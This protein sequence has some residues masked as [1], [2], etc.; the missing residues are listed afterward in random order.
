M[1]VKF[2]LVNKLQNLYLDEKGVKV[3]RHSGGEDIGEKILPSKDMALS[4]YLKV[5]EFV[6]N[7]LPG[8]DYQKKLD[9][10]SCFYTMTPDEHF[11]IDS[12]PIHKFSPNL[13]DL[14]LPFVEVQQ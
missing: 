1:S 2:K 11:L 6:K 3:A 8:I 9:F 4:D 14:Y 7:Y 12:Y 10:K 5:D 13:L